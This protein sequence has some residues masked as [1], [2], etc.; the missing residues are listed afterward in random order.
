MLINKKENDDSL[1]LSDMFQTATQYQKTGNFAQAE[2]LYRQILQQKP[3]YAEAH[4]KLGIV[5]EAQGQYDAAIKAYQNAVSLTPDYANAHYN[6]ANLLMMQSKLSAAVASYQQAVLYKPD[7]AY[8]HCNLGSALAEL[9]QIKPAIASYRQALFYLPDDGEI[10]FNLGLLLLTLGEYEE[11]WQ[12]HEYRYHPSVDNP[13]V[14]VPQLAFPQWQGQSLNGKSIV[15]WYEQGLGDAIQF[16]RYAAVLKQ[17]H[18]AKVTLVCDNA[19]KL[20]FESL[21]GV[22]KVLTHMEAL[23]ITAHD[24]WTFPLSIPLYCHTTV[25]TIPANIPYL[26]ALPSLTRQW[27]VKLPNG[28][29]RIGLVWK[30]STT[31]KNDVNRSIPTLKLLAPLWNADNCHFI[32]LQKGRDEEV[33]RFSS[34]YPLTHL[35]AGIQSFSDTAAIITQLDLVITIDTAVAH[36]AGA[37]GKPVWIVLP[38][39]ADWRWQIDREDSPWYPTVRLFRQKDPGNW[40]D[41]FERVAKELQALITG[42][43]SVISSGIIKKEEMNDSLLPGSNDLPSD[44]LASNAFQSAMQYHHQGNFAQAEALY[45]QI[46]QQDPNHADALHFLGVLAH[47]VGQ[48]EAAVALISK[49]INIFPTSS[50]MYCNLGLAL[51]ALGKR[52]AAVENYQK[53]IVLQPDYPDAYYNLGNTLQEQGKPESAIENYQKALSLNPDFALAHNN[54]GNVFKQQNNLESAI[55]CYL[56]AIATKPDYAEAHYNLGVTQQAQGKYANAFESYQKALSF[57]SDYPET[58]SALGIL[59]LG[60]GQYQEGWRHCEARY[61]ARLKTKQ[62][63]TPDFQFPHWQGESILG[64][65]LLICTEQGLG[66]E[67]QFCR[68]VSLLKSQGAR[69]ISWICKKPLKALLKT[70]KGIDT[71]FSTEEMALI[72]PHDYWTF[73]LTVP[74]HCKTTLQSIPATVPYLYADPKQRNA[75]ASDLH[76]I[77]EFKVGVCWKGNPNFTGDVLRSPGISWFKTLFKLSGVKFFTL[78]PNT[79]EEFILNAGKSGVDRGHEINAASFE[80]AAALIMN[81]DLVITSCTSICHLAGALG[82]PVWIVLPFVADWRWLIN[83]EDSPWYPTARLFRQSEPGNWGEVFQRVENRLKQVIAGETEIV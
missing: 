80:E 4:Y 25:E 5:F 78:Q 34:V 81:L 76:C 33:L 6:M 29:M 61:D 15:I 19:L 60:L 2:T 47:Q 20:L 43:K 7:F 22:D 32:S 27:Q 18:A 66:D 54:L 72:P 41:V 42:E 30:G 46:L 56:A 75:I 16:S 70:L 50:G 28:K 59:L 64:K 49:A 38:F 11:G 8:A 77:S 24:Y 58:E 37:L 62:T 1:L 82:K 10:H 67:I 73:A 68:Y 36:L 45:R 53:A 14:C 31:H 40:S 3:N 79:R 71:V 48:N 12:E 83:R 9:N 35:G 13:N 69:Q 21:S 39:V 55:S 57:K 52:D 63:F 23:S 51:Q 74:L 65:S 17:Q 44:Q 26:S